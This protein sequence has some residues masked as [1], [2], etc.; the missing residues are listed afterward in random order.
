[1]VPSASRQFAAPVTSMFAR[2]NPLPKIFWKVF[3]WFWLTLLL[4]VLGSFWLGD[5]WSERGEDSLQ[6]A[7]LQSLAAGAESILEEGGLGALRPWMQQIRRRTP[8]HLQLVDAGS[9]QSFR[10]RELPP[11]LKTH[12]HSPESENGLIETEFEGHKVMSYPIHMPDGRVLRLIGEP[13]SHEMA[14]ARDFRLIKRFAGNRMLSALLVTVLLCLLI[15]YWLVRPIRQMQ[16]AAR[17]FGEGDFSVRSGLEKRKDEIGDLARE[18]D[19][20]AERIDSML[21][22]QQRLLRDLSHELRSPLAR[23]QV[24]LELARSRSGGVAVSELNRI[25]HEAIQ[26]DEMIGDMLALVRLENGAEID[27]SD[28]IDLEELVGLIISDANFEFAGRGVHA[29]VVT[30]TAAHL[31]GNGS[32]IRS[33][34]ENVVR[35]A[36]KYSEDHAVVEVR[37][38]PVDEGSVALEVRD[39]G[40]GVPEESLSRIFDPFYRVGEARDRSSGGFGLGLSITARV[41]R[42]HGGS[43]QAENAEGGGLRVKMLLPTQAMG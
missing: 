36:M 11:H 40:S 15:A 22:T 21:Q 32:L 3:L 41:I 28:A 14:D 34:I 20:M 6:Q 27:R 5:L 17:R 12:L 1:M 19:A 23:L 43:I 10:G 24:A 30:S 4:T 42:S 25:E 16:L 8:L 39:F 35:N 33:A 7:H 26:I 37:L 38:T 9:T 18:F 2:I 31:Q 13:R 29:D